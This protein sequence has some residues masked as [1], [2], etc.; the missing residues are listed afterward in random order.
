MTWNTGRPDA[1]ST[2]VSRSELDPLGEPQAKLV[3]FNTMSGHASS[4]VPATVVLET[5]SFSEAT[6]IGNG[7]IRLALKAPIRS[8][9]G[10]RS[11]L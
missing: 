9:I 3:A 10:S 1:S 11:P 2:V 4:N 7:F 5:G 8:F 6:N